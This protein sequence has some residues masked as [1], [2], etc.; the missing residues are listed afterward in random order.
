MSKKTLMI[1]GGSRYVVPLIL[2]AKELD[3]FTITVDYIPNNIAHSYS[4]LYLNISVIDKEAVLKAA[5]KYKIDG[6]TAFACDPAVCTMAYVS[7]KLGLPSVGP[8]DSVCILQ[9]KD[10]F[11]LFLKENGFNVPFSGSYTTISDLKK[12]IS[13]FSFPLIVKPTDSAGSKGVSKVNNP[14]MLDEAFKFAMNSSISKQIIVEEFIEPLGHPSDSDCYSINGKLVFCSFSNQFFDAQSINPFV[15]CGFTWP[16][17]IESRH[18]AYLSKE[19]QRLI[20]LLGMKTSIYN[21]ETRVSK[22]GTPYIMEVSPRGGGNRIAEMLFHHTNIDLI[23]K[24]LI[25]CVGMADADI[26]FNERTNKPVGEVIL[27]SNID[28]NFD[29]VFISPKYKSFVIEEDLWIEKNDHINAFIGANNSLGTI[30]YTNF[31]INDFDEILKE[32]RVNLNE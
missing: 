24:H 11:R 19:L 3:I 9:N 2:K 16:S 26:S 27:H 18:Q 21:V 32:T 6:I 29:C 7:N 28:G 31:D 10:K 4:D 1:L 12:D 13:K 30:V 15:P 23:K 25:D 20:T 22:N 5:K 8:Y 14:D 17:Q